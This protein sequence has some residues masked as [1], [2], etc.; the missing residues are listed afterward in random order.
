MVKDE[1][2]AT[3]WVMV[4][5]RLFSTVTSNYLLTIRLGDSVP[6]KDTPEQLTMQLAYQ[7]KFPL[8]WW[9]RL[10]RLGWLRFGMRMI[11]AS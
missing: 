9:S 10:S 3:I 11:A 5:L 8:L 4:Y 7:V 6:P 1:I 2:H